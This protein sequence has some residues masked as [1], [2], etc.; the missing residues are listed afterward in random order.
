MKNKVPATILLVLVLVS[1]GP[2]TIA[3]PTYIPS[4]TFELLP[5]LTATPQPIKLSVDDGYFINPETS[6]TITNNGNVAA[7]N[8]VVEVCPTQ[9][10]SNWHILEDISFFLVYSESNKLALIQEYQ[11]SHEDCLLFDKSKSHVGVLKF[12]SLAPGKS[13]KINIKLGINVPTVERI[14][15][16]TVHIKYPNNIYRITQSEFDSL[17]SFSFAM[18]KAA[19]YLTESTLIAKFMLMVDCDDCVSEKKSID[20]YG[21]FNSINYSCGA[22]ANKSDFYSRNECKVQVKYVIPEKSPDST[23][24]NSNIYLLASFENQN[25]IFVDINKIEFEKDSP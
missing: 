9:I 20:F 13:I 2:A 5:T 4:S 1:C 6:I 16:G 18:D 7:K 22:E 25:Y 24:A 14:Y 12:A 19:R 17:L 8:L 11:S 23:I 10:N 15:N 3:A 21:G